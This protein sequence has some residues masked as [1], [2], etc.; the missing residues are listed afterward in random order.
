MIV[1]GDWNT[2]LDAN[3]DKMGGIV[4][5]ID[6][7]TL[8]MNSLL[9]DLGLLDIWRLKNPIA[10]RDTFRQ[11]HPLVQFRLDYL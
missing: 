11:R 6:T 4:K 8:E 10:K 1:G 7:K 9:I 5:K 2:I 3:L